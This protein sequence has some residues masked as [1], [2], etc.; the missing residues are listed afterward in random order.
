MKRKVIQIAD[1]TQLVSLPRAWA[2]KNNILKGQEL[3]VVEDGNKVVIYANT[4][5]RLNTIEID[6]SG[7]TPRLADRFVGRAYQAGYD[8]LVISFDELEIG[9]A[10]QEKVPELLGFEIFDQSR[11]QL[12]IKS[13]SQKL[14]I[15]FDSALRK[16]FLI[17]ISMA[18]TV[19]EAL[20]KGDKKGL[21]HVKYR[22]VDLNKFCYFC[23]RAINKGQYREMDNRILYYLVETLEDVG[24][25][26]KEIADACLKVTPSEKVLRGLQK[27]N[28]IFKLSYEFF[29]KPDK[30]KA[31]DTYA[32]FEETKQ[33]L[34]SISRSP[35]ANEG[36]LIAALD[37]LLRLI[38]HYVTM[39]LDTLQEFRN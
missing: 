4:A 37:Y 17:A 14:E 23:L 2:K 24:D 13:L 38:Y 18:D 10:L 34:I 12:V 29:Y 16:A 15:D 20:A 3:D 36:R 5:P 31:V 11:N 6:L 7:L 39:R 8:E 28:Q 25:T 26:Y 1:S 27:I 35:S 9:R 22:D 33:F 32:R 19:A 30:K 21:S